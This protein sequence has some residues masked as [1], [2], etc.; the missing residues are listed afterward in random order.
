MDQA[1]GAERARADAAEQEARARTESERKA[2]ERASALDAA[3]AAARDALAQA[4]AREGSAVREA[5]RTA[6]ELAEVRTRLAAAVADAEGARRDAEEKR[7]AL[8]AELRER[9]AQLAAVKA[10]R[11]GPEG[12]PGAPTPVAGSGTG[13]RQRKAPPSDAAALEPRKAPELIQ[14]ARP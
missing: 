8:E 14:P 12:S 3:L 2:V 10:A 4:T 5:G 9:T 1:L 6:G 11:P 13:S 7:V